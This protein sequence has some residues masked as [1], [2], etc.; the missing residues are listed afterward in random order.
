MERPKPTL[1]KDLIRIKG[2]YHEIKDW[3]QDPRGYFLIRT[4]A[5]KQELELGICKKDNV[6]EAI[7]TGKKPQDIYFTA[8][9]K[10]YVSRMDHAAYLGKELQKAYLAMKNSLEYVQDSE[11]EIS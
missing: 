5:K 3:I 6:I 2:Y 10:G 1:S 7:I 11:L 4:N 8:I 9:E